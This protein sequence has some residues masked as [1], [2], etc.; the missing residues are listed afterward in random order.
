MGDFSW[1]DVSKHLL[2]LDAA[3]SINQSVVSPKSKLVDQLVQ[4][5]LLIGAGVWG[6]LQKCGLL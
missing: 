1:E 4:L 2:I 3:L 6:Y 5:G